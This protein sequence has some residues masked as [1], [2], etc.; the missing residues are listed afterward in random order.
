MDE[1]DDKKKRKSGKR[2]PGYPFLGLEEAIQRAMILWDK[3]KNNS[4][5]IEVVYKHLG[6]GFIGGYGGRV[7]AAMKHFDLIS[8]EKDGIKLTSNAVDLALHQPTDEKYTEII[9]ELALKPVIYNKLFNEYKSN[10]PSD[11]TLKIKL[12][13]DYEFNPD[14]VDGFLSDFKKTIEFA[15]LHE[16]ETP[17][18]EKTTNVEQKMNLQTR[19]TLKATMPS[20]N[21]SATAS[22]EREIAHYPIGQ[23][24]K[25]RILVSG[26]S[27]VT[28]DTI[29]KLIGLLELNK[30]DLP[31]IADFNLNDKN[32]TS[33][34]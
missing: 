22:S 2:S 15:N 19:G 18:Q 31:E 8:E 9:K 4:I 33:E 34:Q 11:A 25:A 7:I 6:Y 3:D 30:D 21:S 29:K 1:K 16:V 17:D 24:L 5:P 10:L 23:G 26:A 13:K 27:P 14:K 28:G 20:P 32:E 12:I